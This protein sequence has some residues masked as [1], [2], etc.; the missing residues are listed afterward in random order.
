MNTDYVH[1]NMKSKDEIKILILITYL[2]FIEI[3]K[4]IY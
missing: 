2:N 1:K 4:I 3:N